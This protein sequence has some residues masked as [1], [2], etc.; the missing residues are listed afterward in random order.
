MLASTAQT[1]FN[2]SP[3]LRIHYLFQTNTR[4]CC[5]KQ[6]NHLIRAVHAHSYPQANTQYAIYV[7]TE[8]G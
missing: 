7:Q 5:S 4:D 3:M 2:L 1:I 6:G 8:G